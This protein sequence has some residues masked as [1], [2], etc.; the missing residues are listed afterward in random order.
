MND[1]K[2]WKVL[3]YVAMGVSAAATLLM[4]VSS[5]KTSQIENKREIA[6]QIKKLGNSHN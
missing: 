5:N 1:Y 2:L 4:T 6:E 3:G